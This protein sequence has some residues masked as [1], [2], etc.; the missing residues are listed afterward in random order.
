MITSAAAVN[1]MIAGQEGR[2]MPDQD[3]MSFDWDDVVATYMSQPWWVWVTGC[4]VAWIGLKRLIAS[5]R[6]HRDRPILSDH[7]FRQC[8]VRVDYEAGT[9]TLPR[10]DTFPVQ[11]VRGL[12]WEDYRRAGSYHAIIDVDDLE[13]P[14]HPVGFS[15]SASPESFVSRLR[16]AIEKAGGPR[17]T[18]AA[19][20]RMEIVEKDLSDP[21]MAAVATRVRLLGWRRSFSRTE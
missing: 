15:T 17:F 8:G 21:I 14:V 1:T 2:L 18:A 4:V 10:G 7:A 13:R 3:S 6:A 5:Y 12:R 9:V 20:D 19:T 16:T 11:R